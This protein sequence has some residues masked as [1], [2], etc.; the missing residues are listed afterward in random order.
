MGLSSGGSGNSALAEDLEQVR[1]ELKRLRRQ[2]A[3]SEDVRFVMRRS[4]FADL[5]AQ[6]V[7]HGRTKTGA[8]RLW[9][10]SQAIHNAARTSGAAAEVGSYRGGSAWFIAAT[11]KDVL[12]HEIPIEI[13]DTFEGH[14]EDKLSEEDMPEHHARHRFTTTSYEGVRDHLAQFEQA[15]VHKGEFSAVAPSLPEAEYR[16][17]HLDVDLYASMRD[18]LRYFGPRVAKGGVIVLDDYDS[19]SCPG[20]RRAAEEYLAADDSFQSWNPHTKQL[21][22]VKCR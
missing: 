8:D 2:A 14:P 20:V 1:D 7:G 16:F 17:V 6:V 15:T 12:G 22:L 21:V 9:I 10:I 11:F 3:E 13:I 4:G 5:H 19:P 18:G